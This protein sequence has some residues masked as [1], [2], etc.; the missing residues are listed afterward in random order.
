M[1]INII[2]LIFVCF[3][4]VIGITVDCFLIET[5]LQITT[6]NINRLE[7]SR[8]SHMM[9]INRLESQVRGLELTVSTLGAFISTLAYNNSDL[10]IPGEILRIIAQLNVS[11][12]KTLPNNIMGRSGVTNRSAPLRVLDDSKPQPEKKVP[13]PLKSIA[14]SP[15]LPTPKS[16]FFSSSYSH[17]NQQKLG[18][19]PGEKASTSSLKNNGLKQSLSD[20]SSLKLLMNDE[21]SKDFFKSMPAKTDQPLLGRILTDEDRKALG[22]MKKESDFLTKSNSMPSKDGKK[23]LKTS[24]SSYELGKSESESSM[25]D[26]LPLNSDTVNICFGGTT[27]LKTIRPL[28]TRNES[29]SSILSQS[30]SSGSLFEGNQLPSNKRIELQIVEPT[31]SECTGS[32]SFDENSE[33]VLFNTKSSHREGSYDKT[34][35]IEA[36]QMIKSQV[37]AKQPSLLT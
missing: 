32:S 2:S 16:S 23:L 31:D 8:S 36:E 26:I 28:K 18:L 35:G 19:L 20:S 6:S 21:K 14:S 3:S 12:R 29:C 15:N 37:P 34:K 9:Q 25:S 30:S 33:F 4:L 22:L 7:T 17:I 27:K 1:C 24:Q 11:E 13:P 5:F 10:E